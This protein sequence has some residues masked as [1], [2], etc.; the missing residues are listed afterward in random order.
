MI[1]PT[2]Y[3]NMLWKTQVGG[4]SCIQA[5]MQGIY[6]PI[7][8][9]PPADYA[10][11]PDM[12]VEEYCSSDSAVRD[13][14]DFLHTTGLHESFAPLTHKE[15]QIL[16][17]ENCGLVIVAEAW[18]PVKYQKSFGLFES[19]FVGSPVILVYENSD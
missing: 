10:L 19:P 18:I 2:R 14:Q 13:V 17:S 9:K 16:D 15:M 7:S 11:Y 3:S 5:Y 12:T 4:L 8:D 1:V 6:V